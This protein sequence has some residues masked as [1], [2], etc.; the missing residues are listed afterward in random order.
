MIQS[1]TAMPE[2]TDAVKRAA[3]RWA[4]LSLALLMLLSSLGV[5]IPNVALPTIGTVFAASLLQV[6]WVVVAYLLAITVTIVGVGRLGDIVGRRKILLVGIVVF[7]V[8]SL[9]C[10]LAPSLGLLVTFRMVQGVG[11]AIL[12]ALTMAFVR[13][14]VS[15]E[16]TGS[17]M[18]LLGTMSAIGTALGPSLGGVLVGSVGWQSIFWIMVPLGLL[19]LL[20]AHR[21]LQ[22]PPHG[23]QPGGGRFDKLGMMLLAVTLAAYALATTSEGQALGWSDG[24]LFAI[25]AVG[26][27]LFVWIEARAPN[28][29]IRLSVFGDPQLSAS[30]VMNAMVSTVMMAT[31]VVG[32]FFLSGALG[33]SEAVLGMVMAIG[34]ITSALSGIPAGR[35]TDRFGAQTMVALG[36]IQMAT[37]C[38]ALAFLPIYFGIA[39]YAVAL[40]LLTPGYQL[41]QAAN[42]TSVMAN[43]S[44]EERGVVSGMLSLSRNLGLITGASA[45]GA[46]FAAAVGTSAIASAPPSA[47]AFA[48]QV[49]FGT[50]GGLM[51]LALLFAVAS[52][53][54][55]ARSLRSD[56]DLS[57]DGNRE[58][59]QSAG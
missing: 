46:L 19:G 22:D 32:P 56:A 7:T 44:A 33:L 17:A 59:E 26:V 1:Q 58:K 57:A 23:A 34:P 29:L 42:N 48:M 3:D 4:V 47:L 52:R 53:L 25:A 41:F 55:V 51:I 14:T 18:G 37:G 11:A 15:K 54:A 6:Q 30:L 9:L 49:T 31:L 36:L 21:N 16:R 10:A 28:P 13:E 39:G 40:I 27:V 12:M 45:M 20:L 2:G 5:S 8:A 35:V 50:A 24:S 38:F 43:V